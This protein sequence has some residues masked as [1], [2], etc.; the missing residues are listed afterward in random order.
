MTKFLSGVNAIRLEYYENGGDAL[1]KLEWSSPAISRQVIPAIQLFTQPDT[2]TPDK[3]FVIY[4]NPNNVH[5]VTVSTGTNFQQ[6]AHILIYD[7]LGQI[8]IKNSISS[9]GTQATFPINL[10][11]GVYIVKLFTGNKTYTAKL[12]VL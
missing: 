11:R 3:N 5:I 7:M 6:G 10:S 9:P 8:L 4:P 12:M 2:L 1:C